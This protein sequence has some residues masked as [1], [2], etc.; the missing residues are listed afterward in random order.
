[1]Q[2]KKAGSTARPT[3]NNPFAL[4][5]MFWPHTTQTNDRARQ[6]VT[7]KTYNRSVLIVRSA[8][9]WIWLILSTLIMALPVL[10]AGIFSR[11]LCLR[12]SKFWTDSNLFAIRHICGLSCKVHGTE[13][14]PDHA[15]LILSKHQS[16]YE[17]FFLA[18]LFKDFVYVAK[19]SLTLIP[20]FGWVL[21]QLN[22]ILI[23]R[24]SGRS[25]VTQMVEQSKE[26]L[27]DGTNVIIFPEGTRMPI[28]AP[29][30]YRAGGAIVASKIGADVLPIAH[31]AGEYWPR[32][33]FIKWPGEISMHIGPVIHGEGKSPDAILLE[34]QTW[35]ENKMQEIT[36]PDRF[37]YESQRHSRL[38]N[39]NGNDSSNCNQIGK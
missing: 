37:P 28:N 4:S 34:A 24:K 17:T 14:I 19:R 16:T 3:D 9:F 36:V 38:I 12:L 29:P 39:D 11:P 27:D 1:M 35:I 30:N 25:A 15:C 13:N 2:H 33:G 10:I 31:N 32:M 18:S 6:T 5:G 20:I 8:V 7:E 23:N 26:L 21:L 22:F